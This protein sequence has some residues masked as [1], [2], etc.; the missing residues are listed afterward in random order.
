MIFFFIFFLDYFS[1]FICDMIWRVS[2]KF[3]RVLTSCH[4]QKAFGKSCC[5]LL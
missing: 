3:F 4:E 5:C 1:L 2:V